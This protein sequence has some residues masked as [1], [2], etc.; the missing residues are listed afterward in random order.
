MKISVI[1]PIY[2]AEKYLVRCVNS[3]LRQSYG[4]LEVILVDDG[5]TDGSGAM[6]N[7]F[8]AHDD[9]IK[10]IH[11]PN[12]GLS[13]ARNSG[14]SVSSGEYVMFL[15]SDDYYA[16]DIMA[17]I[18]S[19]LEN[20]PCDVWVG[21]AYAVDNAGKISGTKNHFP[22]VLPRMF[23]SR[24]YLEL[25]GENR[26]YVSF[27][28]QFM[29]YRADFLRQNNCRFYDGIYHEDELW[30]PEVILKAE[31][32][33]RSNRLFYYHVYQ[34]GSIMHSSNHEKRATI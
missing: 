19:D 3:L 20:N 28:V 9:R 6:C 10:V 31:T 30:T 1:V 4:D 27:C 17:D 26:E 13:D 8:A 12:G 15:D 24:E 16:S 34:E 32:V 7:D 33:Y 25:L 14:L 11:K 23:G 29:A 18:V 22:N 21:G 5:S 2:N